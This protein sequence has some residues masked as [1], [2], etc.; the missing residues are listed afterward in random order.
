M[1]N[2]IILI[3]LRIFKC[4]CIMFE[5]YL[6]DDFWKFMFKIFFYIYVCWVYCLKKLVKI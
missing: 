6:I 2:E 5:L 4:L 3:V 1:L